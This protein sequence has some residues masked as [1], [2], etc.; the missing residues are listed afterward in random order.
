M[1]QEVDLTF[2]NNQNWF[3][4]LNISGWASLYDLTQGVF[5]MQARTTA[6][7]I[8]YVYAWSSSPNDGVGGLIS[9]DVPSGLLLITAPYADMRYLP[10]G[11]YGYDLQYIPSLSGAVVVTDLCTGSLTVTQGYT[12]S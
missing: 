8:I 5:R 12:R 6:A 11:A 4:P 10:A 3:L 7:N 2:T 9:Y 1:P